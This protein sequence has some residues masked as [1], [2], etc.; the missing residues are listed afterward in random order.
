MKQSLF[1]LLFLSI[2]ICRTR[3]QG[4]I[5]EPD[6]YKTYDVKF[7]SLD[8]DI[9]DT[10]TFLKGNATIRIMFNEPAD[11]VVFNFNPRLR[12]DSVLVDGK[13]ASFGFQADLFIAKAN[14]RFQKGNQV[15]V[16]VYYEGEVN[17]PSFFSSVTNEKDYYWK[18]PVTWTLSE[19]FGAKH[20]F[21]CKQQLTDKAD[22]CWI[23]LTVPKGR[24]AGSAGILTDT[25][26]VGNNKMQFRWK[27]RY[28]VAYYLISYA[29]ADYY[30]Y[31]FYTKI[32]GANDSLLVKNY[33]YN[34]PDYLATTR[35]DINKTG[36]FLRLYSKLFGLYPFYEEKYG[37]CVAPIGGGMEHQTMTTLA[38]FSYTLVSHELAHQ[39]FGDYVTCAS[40]QDIWVNEGFASY[41]EYL[42]YENLGT[43]YEADSWMQYA[44]QKALRE[45]EGSVFVPASDA[46]D[47]DRIFSTN[48]SY[49]KGAVIIHMLRK[50]INNDELFFKSLRCFLAKYHF[51][52]ATA[53]DL[54]H[55]FEKETGINLDKF[56]DQWYYGK[57]YPIF[58]V[59][60]N[61][62]GDTL[63]LKVDQTSSSKDRSFFT[64]PFEIKAS[65][66]DYDTTFRLEQTS[67]QQIFKIK[68]VKP[69]NTL[70]LDPDNWLLKVVTNITLLPE[71]PSDDNYFTMTPNPFNGYLTIKFKEDPAKDEK[72]EIINLNGHTLLKMFARKKR[73]TVVN[74]DSLK[75]GT[76][77]L[78]VSHDQEKYVRKIVKVNTI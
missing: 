16:K 37:H 23:F 41:A 15:D 2:F 42:A 46:A 10:S 18:V 31:S 12:I 5:A 54:K 36:D 53:E 35:D 57:G 34:R 38:N 62:S 68:L 20:W 21:P 17:T 71:I 77:L 33:I 25:I 3:A 70:E 22:S 4:Y 66:A 27:T 61:L 75:P 51:G 65:A 19:P 44:Q 72:I 30:D 28:P 55:V 26:P 60:W 1:L 43:K 13:K 63:L 52:T 48:L 40:W 39:W 59:S 50:I 67:G 76:Y 7:Y 6:W 11:S 73:E 24:K 58:D 32:E 29:V 45:P 78:K 14:T 47:E 74:T 49:K 69:V 8:L 64:T 56:F 9:S